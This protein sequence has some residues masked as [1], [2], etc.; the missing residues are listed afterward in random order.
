MNPLIQFKKT[1][2]LAFLIAL[3]LVSFGISPRVAAQ[4]VP[5]TYQLSFCAE[6]QPIGST[7]FVGQELVLHA[8]VADSLGTPASRG[9]VVFQVCTRGGHAIPNDPQP[10]SACDID[11]TASWVSLTFPRLPLDGT[12][13]LSCLPAGLGNACLGYGSVQSVRTVGFRFKY[14]GQGSG[15]ANGIDTKDVSWILP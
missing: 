13:C 8:Y 12:T 5:G 11:H 6:G 1:T 4:G 7:L 14:L 3:V 2:I 15:I 10:S 9:Q